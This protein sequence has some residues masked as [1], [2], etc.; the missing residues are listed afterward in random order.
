M[1]TKILSVAIDARQ[2][3]I[4]AVMF[5]KASRSIQASATGIGTSSKAMGASMAHTAAAIKSMVL[6]LAG[7]MGILK[8]VTTIAKFEEAMATLGAVTGEVDFITKETTQ[9]FAEMEKVARALGSTTRFSASEASRGMLE[10]ARAGFSAN[11]SMDAIAHT[12]DLATASGIGL[13]EASGF[14]ANTVRQFGLEAREAVDVADA[15]ILVSNKSN[16]TV[17]ELAE[18]M[19][20]VGTVSASVGA[21]VEETAS[22]IGILG[23]RGVKATMAGTQLRGVLIALAKPT[24]KA[25]KA[26]EELGLTTEELDPAQ[27]SLHDIAVKLDGAFSKLGNRYDALGLASE[28]FGRRNASASLAMAG[29]ADKMAELTGLAVESKTAHQDM[30]DVMDDTVVG[31]WYGL[32]S[33]VE[34]AMLV[35]GDAGALGGLRSIIDTGAEMVRIWADVEGA[36]EKAGAVAKIFAK[37]LEIIVARFILIR[38]LMLV[39]LLL[40]FKTAMVASTV[41]AGGLAAGIKSIGVAIAA[42]PIGLILTGIATG[43]I[44]LSDAVAK[45]ERQQEKQKTLSQ[46]IADIVLSEAD[47]V[48]RLAENRLAVLD[49]DGALHNPEMERLLEERVGILGEY[50]KTL[51]AH[52]ETNKA[53]R[54]EYGERYVD[55]GKL[56]ELQGTLANVKN[57]QE[58]LDETIVSLGFNIGDLTDEIKGYTDA[59]SASDLAISNNI[60]TIEQQ[61]AVINARGDSIEETIALQEA[62]ATAHK[63]G[64]DIEGERFNLLVDEIAKRN[65]A[66]KSLDQY[67]RSQDEI[68]NPELLSNMEQMIQQLVNMG[69]GLDEARDKAMQVKL[70]GEAMNDA[71][72]DALGNVITGAESAKDALKNLFQFIIDEALKLAVL[73]PLK[74]MMGGMFGDLAKSFSNSNPSGGDY[75]PFT[76]TSSNFQFEARGGVYDGSRKAFASGGVVTAP[77]LFNYAGGQGLM[78]E[79]GAEAIMPLKRDSKGNLG[80]ASEGGGG[81]SKNVTVNM[82]VNTPDADSFRRSKIQIQRDL[83]NAT[84]EI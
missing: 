17:S 57:E 6:P 55:N 51:E 20:M 16:T 73:N 79:A 74:E 50:E 41:A 75:N 39:P 61:M 78:G 76:D 30:A 63:D 62:L 2:A 3:R 82:T 1:T 31:A 64:I 18:A 44:M 81:A 77:T 59:L 11:E 13:A 71:F 10:L 72:S 53:L 52:I 21:S 24:E 80:V 48:Q 9:T 43:Y 25:Q 69:M 34:E 65:E 84:T 40:G 58:R 60:A 37:T 46:D 70:S 23:D 19:K 66:K 32:K 7:L 68:A 42:N 83:K 5:K 15:F 8:T 35:M 29:S 54:E 28:I 38:G 67:L 36:W 26:M 45:N 14:V 47:A 27:N 56:E 33:A 49:A 12:L 22:V 4:G